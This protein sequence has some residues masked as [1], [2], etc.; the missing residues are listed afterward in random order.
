MSDEHKHGTK[1]IT[2][3]VSLRKVIVKNVDLQIS[4]KTVNPNINYQKEPQKSVYG[5]GGEETEEDIHIV[6]VSRYILGLL[7]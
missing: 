6:K 4:T 2:R 1:N 3:T 5:S 7:L